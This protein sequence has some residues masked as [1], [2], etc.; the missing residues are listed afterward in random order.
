[1]PGKSYTI[2]VLPHARAR[3]KKLQLSRKAV[4]GAFAGLA[5]LAVAGLTLPPLLFKLASDSREI[6]ELQ[7]SNQSLTAEKQRFESS[8]DDLNQRLSAFENQATKLASALGIEELPSSRPA[9]G[10]A[11]G[12]PVEVP[13]AVPFREEFRALN[14]R[15]SSLGLSMEQIDTAWTEREKLLAATPSIMPVRGWFSH[16]YGWRKDPF[17]GKRAFHRGVDIVAPQGTPIA[18]PADGVVS[19]A[20]RLG[21]YG[22]SIDISHGYGYVTRY[23]HLSE[24]LVKPGQKVSRGDKIGAVGSTGRSTG[25]HLHYEMFRDGR[26]VNPWKYL[27]D[28][29]F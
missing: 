8:L 23:A 26:R 15:A 27:G 25:P 3:F 14:S 21:P 10:G 28:K 1:M 12:A 7:R 22:K 4:V 13:D 2:L 9:A 19:R 29:S 18:A 11:A 5:V 6:A 16:G 20:G 17:T 24:V